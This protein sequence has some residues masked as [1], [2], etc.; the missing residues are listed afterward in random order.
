MVAEIKKRLTFILSQGKFRIFYD[1]SLQLISKVYRNLV[2][3]CK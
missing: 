2:A 3:I 1:L